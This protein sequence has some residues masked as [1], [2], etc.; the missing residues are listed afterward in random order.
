MGS[1]GT[2]PDFKKRAVVADDDAVN[3]YYAGKILTYRGYQVAGVNNYYDALKAL[4]DNDAHLLLADLRL[5]SGSGLHLARM[6]LER[7]PALKVVLMTAYRDEELLA[8]DS[9]LPLLRV[10]FS[11]RQLINTVHRASP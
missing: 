5:G 3:L 6:A 7:Q 1:A 4:A 10:P 11:S 2:A 9:G 8:H